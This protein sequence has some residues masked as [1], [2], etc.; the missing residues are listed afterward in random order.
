MSAKIEF[1]DIDQAKFKTKYKLI[2]TE[3]EA[4]ENL[5]ITDYDVIVS[6]F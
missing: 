4:G 1:I 5:N 6:P 3:K 2:S